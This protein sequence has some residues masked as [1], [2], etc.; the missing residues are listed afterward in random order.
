MKR[1]VL[2]IL[3]IAGAIALLPA[4]DGGREGDRCNPNLSHDDCSDG[5]S[6]ITP[7]TCVENYCCPSNPTKSTSQYC[8]G[9][10]CPRPAPT[11]AGPSDAPSE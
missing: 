2:L 11:D 5:L 7:A 10:G 3:A 6:C 9:S 4:C 1:T 8:N